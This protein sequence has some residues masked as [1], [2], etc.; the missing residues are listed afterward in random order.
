MATRSR[1]AQGN[2][3]SAPLRRPRPAY[4]ADAAP[5]V[6]SRG[7]VSHPK[8]TGRWAPKRLVQDATPTVVTL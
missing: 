6:K 3:S 4:K 5:V 7:S 1:P 8:D 2:N